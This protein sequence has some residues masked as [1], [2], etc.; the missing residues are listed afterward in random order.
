MLA[1]AQQKGLL[2]IGHNSWGRDMCGSRLLQ[3]QIETL[4]THDCCGS[5]IFLRG[6]AKTWPGGGPPRPSG[7]CTSVSTSE[8]EPTWRTRGGPP[9]S[10]RTTWCVCVPGR[11][12]GR[13]ERRRDG[14]KG[15]A[16]VKRRLC[17]RVGGGGAREAGRGVGVWGSREGRVNDGSAR[18]AA[19]EAKCWSGW[20]AAVRLLR[21][22][23]D[24]AGVEELGV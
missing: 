13:G 21:D 4:P 6:G 16:G 23:R 10:A 5:A 11:G 19:A 8:A 22:S 9:S 2:T 3:M 14:C 24:R 12:G 17:G 1:A 18:Q 15:G 7:S 20:L